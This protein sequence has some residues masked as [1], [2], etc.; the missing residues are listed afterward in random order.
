MR[1]PLKVCA[2]IKDFQGYLLPANEFLFLYLVLS[3]NLE[4]LLQ[5]SDST[6]SHDNCSSIPARQETTS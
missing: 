4:L 1:N 6:S 5:F 2:E 3:Q